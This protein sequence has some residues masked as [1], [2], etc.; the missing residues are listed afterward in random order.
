MT[1]LDSSQR[2]LSALKEARTQIEAIQ[3]EKQER[4]AIVGMA[5]RFPG[6]ETVDEFW[7]LLSQGRVGIRFLSDEELDAAGVGPAERDRPNYV[8]AYASCEDVGGFDAAFFGYSPREAEI[9]EPQHRLFL[10]CAW[11]ALEHAGY[12]PEQYEGKIGVYGGAALNSYLINLHSN[13]A[14]RDSVDGVQAV[15][16]NVMGLMPT[17]VS[18]KLNLTGPSCGI[19]TGCSTSLVSVHTASQSILRGECD[20]ALAGG[21]SISSPTPSGYIFQ[22]DGVLS[23][24][25]HCRAFD[26]DGQGTV[27][28][29]GVGIV[30][31][32]RLSRAIA[33]GDTIYAV[34]KGSA[35][36]NDGAQKVGLTA[37]SVTGQA[38]V[39]TA[40]LEHADVSPD[41]INYVEAHGTGTALGDPIE[42]SA[43]TK[44]FRSSTKGDTQGNASNGSTNGVDK[45]CAIGSVKTNVGHLDAAAGIS[46]L[47]KTTLAMHHQKIPPSLNFQSPNPKIDFDSSPFEVNTELVPW[48]RNGTPRRAGVSSFGMGGTN[49][50]I[51][52]EEGPN[53]KPAS[54]N[55]SRP[56]QLLLLS[57]KTTSALDTA[58]TDLAN[59][60]NA[61]PNQ[62][63][64]NIAHTLQRGRRSLPHRRIAI[65]ADH[66]S[67][68]DAL[69]TLNAQYCFTQSPVADNPPITFMF[70]GQGSQYVNMGRDL[71]NTEP[72]FRTW[73]D[74]CCEE[75]N[76]HIDLDVKDLI[77]PDESRQ[78]AD[79]RQ[80]A[81]GRRQNPPLA[82]PRR[83]TDPSKIQNLKSKINSTQ[84]AQPALFTI[85]YALAKLWMSWGIRPQGL[86]GHSIGEYVAAA[87]AGVFSLEDAIALVARRGQLMQ[88]CQPGSM[89]SVAA[90]EVQ[91]VRLLEPETE[92]AVVNGAELCVVSGPEGAI[93]QLE[94]RCQKEGLNARILKTSHGFHSSMMAPVVPQFV[95]QVSQVKLTPPSI[96]MMSNVTGTW[97]T[98]DE[99]TNPNYWG[100][101][102]R[103]TVRFGDGIEKLW[104]SDYPVLLEVGPSRTLATLAKRAQAERP[105]V[106]LTSLRHP[107]ESQ[108]DHALILKTLGLLWLNGTDIDWAGFYAYEQR[109]RVPLPTYPFE[110]QRYWVDLQSS[111]SAS[112]DAVSAKSATKNP[113]ISQWF[114][115]PSWQREALP[116]S[117]GRVAS[118]EHWLVFKSELQLMQ[119]LISLLQSTQQTVIVVQKG[120]CFTQLDADTY[121]INP[122]SPDDYHDL[123]AALKNSNR[124]PQTIIHGWSLVNNQDTSAQADPSEEGISQFSSL[125][126][127]AQAVDR[128]MAKQAANSTASISNG[129]GNGATAEKALST[130]SEVTITVLTPPIHDVTGTEDL[131][132]HNAPLLGACQVIPQEY[133]HIR[134]QVIDINSPSG[135]GS[136]PKALIASILTDITLPSNT[137]DRTCVVAYRGFCRWV[138]S[139]TPLLLKIDESASRSQGF[140]QTSLKQPKHSQE[141]WDLTSQ[142]SIQNP[143]SKIQNPYASNSLTPQLP[144]SPTL[145]IA[146]DLVDGL[147]LYFAQYFAQ[148][149]QAKLILLGRE[150]MPMPDQWE[151]WLGVHGQRDPVSNC[152]RRLQGLAAQEV[153]YEFFSAD[154]TDTDR[155]RSLL[156]QAEEI[157]GPIQGVV[158]AGVMGGQSSCLIADLTP[159]AIAKQF[160]S[161]M[162][163]LLSLEQALGN[164]AI[165]FFWLQSSLSSVV[166]GVG[167]SAYSGANYFMDA[168]AA[169]RNRSA[170]LDT[171]PQWLSVNWDACRDDEVDS[172]SAI[173]G[174]ALVDLAMTPS[175]V[176]D[177]C[178]RLFSQIIQS[179]GLPGPM[180][181]ATSPTDLPQ[182]I[183]D[184]RKLAVTKDLD[185][186]GFN[187]NGTANAHQRPQLS[188][189]YV[190][191]RNSIETAVSEAMQEL[192]G[193]GQVGIHDNFFELGGHSLLAIQAVSRLRNE[194]NVDLP[195]REFLFES[196]TVAG[197]AKIIEEN[198]SDD[199]Q[200]AEGRR[201]K[202]EGGTDED[203][204]SVG[205]VDDRKPNSPP[206]QLTTEQ[207]QNEI[208]DLLSQ[209]ENM[210][211]DD[212]TAQL[213]EQGGQT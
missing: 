205:W 47:I 11:T 141:P 207:E 99:A 170:M 167:F 34:V 93:V 66:T 87:I 150:G 98:A 20:M 203:P 68:T 4:V 77:Y 103:Q 18:Y 140:A 166:G 165:E 43:L 122:A 156:T 40:A 88:S 52:L 75:F 198:L 144:N 54:A 6:A 181:I 113:D 33:D 213:Q 133:P 134:C 100:Q 163:G 160:K 129:N 183:I 157:L 90:S 70:S 91:V 194:F 53:S 143:K 23:P 127:L 15:I 5:G 92:L 10:E 179:S 110:R 80:K 200:K 208:A 178:D 35:I 162:Q 209:V 107:Q 1:T 202:V 51:I 31:L 210:D 185:P 57:A 132:P 175:E 119:S 161:K 29:N 22:E 192:L 159:E 2:I 118:P 9:I 187:N 109:R 195:M 37:P 131:N 56:W 130:P 135:N 14:F 104:Q 67:A 152:I 8:R 16:S 24:D 65:C 176:D 69:A 108:P 28:G 71:Y 136:I 106:V 126:F 95:E 86:I 206:P 177:V 39:I 197:I 154:L 17:R 174:S 112:Q 147:G 155:V 58:T 186:D 153:E 204:D 196:P 101:H 38:E 13:P 73:V 114:Y 158:H 76:K 96:P 12:D 116:L 173:T 89:L 184:A 180:Q 139:Y 148:T 74:R 42:L 191:P 149:H 62:L 48:S 61:N 121:Q 3:R 78:K 125:I 64:A 83:G 30:V 172:E 211:L 182:R 201:Q 120:G 105:G 111:T 60:L 145:L 151:P 50:H 189:T 146:G 27:F 41:T 171:G 82:P 84:Y 102:I 59:H 21:V 46:G 97:L 123:I 36:N 55:P 199:F 94:Q 32:K 19:Q 26:A 169:E 79:P 117:E 142:L 188:T 85:E 137:A 138:Q 128:I 168:L 124:L 115:Q 193:I 190:A 25:G 164:R 81:E 49:A 7:Q 72:T 44:V 45:T 212:V 63:L